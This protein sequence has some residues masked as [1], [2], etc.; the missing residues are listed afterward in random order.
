MELDIQQQDRNTRRQLIVKE[1]EE[2][3]DGE[4][5]LFDRAVIAYEYL[6]HAIRYQGPAY[7]RISEAI[8]IIR[9]S[10]ETIERREGELE[11]VIESASSLYCN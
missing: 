9:R 11:K 2:L 10:P 4:K 8:E 7:T 3:L 1:F 5:D 6:K